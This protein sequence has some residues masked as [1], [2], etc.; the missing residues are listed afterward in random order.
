MANFDPQE[1][2]LR[3][4][5]LLPHDR[6]IARHND[7]GH[8][9]QVNEPKGN[10]IYPSVTGK[11][12]ILKDEGL[13]NYK[14]NRAMDYVF[15][16]YPD[17]KDE[18]IMEHIEKAKRVS[19]D[20]LMDAGDV[21][22][23]IHDLREAIFQQW[24]DT[25][26]KP[27]N[28]LS[29]VPE[30]SDIRVTS[31]IRAL[32]KFVD[33]RD[34]IPVAC[35]LLVYS[36]ELKVAGTLDDLG[37]IRKVIRKADKEDCSHDLFQKGGNRT[38]LHCGYKYTYELAIMDIK[39]SNQFKDHYFFQVALYAKMFAKITGLRPTSHF[40][41]KLSKEDGGYKIED[42]KQASKLGQYATYMIKCNEG[43]EFIKALRK[44]NQKVVAPLLQL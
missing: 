28:F 5:T 32:Q 9:Y 44:D 16:N 20:I 26:I 3:I 7:K 4:K 34:Y 8:F 18:T 23:K 10:P 15:A 21:G 43:M 29:F 6:V 14:M 37:L 17:F 12:Q 25:G 30:G 2:R 1:L 35:E 40:I 11:L 24:M 39:T 38:C 36:H 13:I 42:L 22:T 33:E 31:A 41:C 19:Q 27:E